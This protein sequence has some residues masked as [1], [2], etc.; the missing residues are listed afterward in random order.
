MHTGLSV[1]IVTIGT[2]HTIRRKNL[3]VDEYYGTVV[4]PWSIL[5][6][7]MH[8]P[9]FLTY[10]YIRSSYFTIRKRSQSLV[11]VPIPEPVEPFR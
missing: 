4:D 6:P 11:T 5:S 8:R 1:S 10:L 7:V 9:F 2:V 3:L